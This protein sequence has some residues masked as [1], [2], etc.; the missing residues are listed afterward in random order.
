MT[1]KFWCDWTWRDFA[2]HDMTRY[3][4]VLPL[5]AIEQ[6]G[7]HLPI[8]TDCD[9]SRLY[10][11]VAYKQ[12]PDTM[13]VLYLPLQ[14]LG[15]STEHQEFPGTLTCRPQ[16]L[17]SLWEEIGESIA[18]SGLRRLLFI[19]AHGG[20]TPLLD[21][22]ARQLRAKQ[23]MLA[24]QTSWHRL[25]LPDL[26]G[27]EERKYGLHGGDVETSLMLAFSPNAVRQEQAGH[28]VSSAVRLEQNMTHLR[29]NSPIGFGWMASD[30]NPLGV[31]GDASQATAEKG[32]ACA[33][34][35]AAA[36]I[37]LLQDML[38]FDLSQLGKGP[39]VT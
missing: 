24:V 9:I 4:A 19:N 18:R 30:L 23:S 17:L 1:S 34:T 10:L 37:A 39:L 35:I 5:G 31:A 32:Q 22:V 28:F 13:P 25:G 15:L 6:H 20:N 14:T 21:I 33:E 3:V 8:G 12:T 38:A 16:T 2:D 29:L 26:F 11:D 27:V 7:P 36:F